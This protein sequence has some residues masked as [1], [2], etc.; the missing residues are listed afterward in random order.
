MRAGRHAQEVVA[1][2]DGPTLVSKGPV[3][4]IANL[5][6]TSICNVASSTKRCSGQGDVL[7]GLLAA[8]I[9]AIIVATVRLS[10]PQAQTLCIRDCR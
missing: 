6:Y 10:L 9:P 1:A 8:L 4:A 3:D 2:L 7:A 5:Q